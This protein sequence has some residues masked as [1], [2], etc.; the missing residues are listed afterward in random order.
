M[1]EIFQ[2]NKHKELPHIKKPYDLITHI[3]K[4]IVIQKSDMKLYKIVFLYLWISENIKF[5]LEEE[6]VFDT[7][8]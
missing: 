7:S 5:D 2:H 1:R 8:N 6:Q 4:L 3:E